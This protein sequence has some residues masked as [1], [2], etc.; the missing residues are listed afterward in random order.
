[1]KYPINKEFNVKL[2]GVTFENRQEKLK[3]LS[4]LDSLYLIREPDNKYDANA[5][6]VTLEDGTDV[7]YIPRE[8]AKDLATVMDSG[9]F[10][11]IVANF[12]K[13]EGEKTGVDLILKI[14][15]QNYNLT[16]Y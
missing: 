15:P 5:I 12:I 14:V 6:L 9:H 16:H 13:K 3:R 4:D 8:I 7:G 11:I 10:K 1:M 2:V